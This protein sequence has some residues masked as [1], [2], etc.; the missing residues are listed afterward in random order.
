MGDSNNEIKKTPPPKVLVRG[1][2]VPIQYPMLNH[3]KYDLWAIQ[4]K[5]IVRS[6]C[7]WEALDGSTSVDVE[8]VHGAMAAISQAVPDEVKLANA[9]KEL[10]KEA[11]ETIKEMSIDKDRVKKARTQV[12]KRSQVAQQALGLKGKRIDKQ[13]YKEKERYGKRFD[14]DERLRK[15]KAWKKRRKYELGR[16]PKGKPYC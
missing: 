5:N 1:G 3:E 13:N 16:Q 8:K 2:G 6:L 14:H 11:W 7:V 12:K 9:G 4:R 10:A 15:K